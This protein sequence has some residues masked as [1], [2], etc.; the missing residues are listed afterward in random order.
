MNDEESRFG[1]DMLIA[2]KF[3]SCVQLN[4]VDP[5]SRGKFDPL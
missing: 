1:D 4:K 2:V 5:I 3:Q